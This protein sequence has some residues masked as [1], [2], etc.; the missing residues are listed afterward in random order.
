[1]E[2]N[3]GKNGGRPSEETERRISAYPTIMYFLKSI[4]GSPSERA[5]KASR[6]LRE[7]FPGNDLVA[8]EARL[9]LNEYCRTN[10]LLVSDYLEK[11]PL[12]ENGKIDL[13]VT[14]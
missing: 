6:M 14:S 11:M 2:E 3:D 7:F 10:K 8:T 9:A 13:P 4:E 1:M 12:K 5:R